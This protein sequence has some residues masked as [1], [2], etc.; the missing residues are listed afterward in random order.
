MLYSRAMSH[1][2][3]PATVA[4]LLLLVAIASIT[5]KQW[6][7]E[8]LDLSTVAALR[9]NRWAIA[10][11]VVSFAARWCLRQPGW[12]DALRVVAAL[13][14]FVP[15]VLYVRDILRWIRGLDELQ[16]R[17]QIEALFYVAAAMGSA[18]LAVDLLQVAGFLRSFHW[19]WELAYAVTFLLWSI[20]CA[21]AT[22][23]YS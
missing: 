4:V 23:R 11:L 2:W 20:G 5:R 8:S 15:G 7:P 18:M 9:L 6:F 21:V 10:A 19:G 13:S 17:I 22:R 12:S 16:R 1:Y 3:L 14:P